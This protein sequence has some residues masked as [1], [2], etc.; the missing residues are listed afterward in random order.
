MRYLVVRDVMTRDV[1][2]VT[3]S[4][5][6]KDVAR[7]LDEHKISAVPVVDERRRVVGVV[8][9]SDLLLKHEYRD[10][11]L[12]A[13]WLTS[14]QARAVQ[15][16]ACGS[17]AGDL[18]TSPAVTVGGSSSAEEAARRMDVHRVKRLPVVD[19]EGSLVGIVSRS[20]LV[21]VFLRSDA[22]IRD[23]VWR[24][25]S[26]RV[27]LTEAGTVYV[28]VRDG[29]VALRGELERKSSVDIAEEMIRR[30]DGV[31]D[32][33]NQLNFARDDSGSHTAWIT[34]PT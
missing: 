30:I 32:V 16:K 11:R 31:V 3:A 1:V 15:T 19:G 4:T 20:D 6:F 13:G 9:E 22:E 24:E 28:D 27:L 12:R 21:T 14:A 10:T 2:T 8:S 18:M 23:E 34:G 29:V 7:L 26:Q 33:V 5:P 17:V 25:I